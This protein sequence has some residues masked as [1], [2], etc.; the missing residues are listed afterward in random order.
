MRGAS[1]GKSHSDP[2]WCCKDL[3]LILVSSGANPDDRGSSFSCVTATVCFHQRF[4]TTRAIAADRVV[5]T[6]MPALSGSYRA[7]A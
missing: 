3:A 6:Q 2:F 7:M 5:V 1:Y 4:W